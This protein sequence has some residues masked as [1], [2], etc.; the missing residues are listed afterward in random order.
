MDTLVN[1][2]RIFSED[3]GMEFGISKYDTLMIKRGIISKSEGIQLPN[4]EFIKNIEEGEGY[5]Y[6]GIMEAD[7][8]KNL[9]MKEKLSK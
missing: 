9:E 7:G 2:V 6:L 1:T 5:K 4:D 3:I 8:F